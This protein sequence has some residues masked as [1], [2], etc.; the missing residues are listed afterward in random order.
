MSTCH[1]KRS[2]LHAAGGLIVCLVAGIIWQ[3][4]SQAA[5]YDYRTYGAAEARKVVQQPK[6]WITADH[7]K[8]QALQRDFA[9]PEEVTAA[10]LTCH[11]EA[12]MQV[13]KTIHWMWI[14]PADTERKMGKNGLTLNN[15]C[16]SVHSNQPRCT[17]CHAGYGW[18]DASFDFSSAERVD[19]L[20]CHDST[21]TYKKFPT[22]A[23]YPVKE[24]TPFGKETF[25]PP[26]YRVVAASVARP[27]RD[28]CGNCHF[29][30]GGG[31]GVKHGDLD[32]SMLKPSRD[33]DVHMNAEGAN[34][35]CQRCHTTEAHFIAGRSY[36][37][38]AYTERTSLI[39]NDLVKRISCESCHTDKPHKAGHKANDHT[40]RVACQTCHIP[41]YARVLPTKISWDWSQAGRMKEGKP[42]KIMGA[43]D[44]PV[45]DSMK[46]AF[47]WATNVEPEYMWYNG[48][49]DYVLAT[50]SINPT[51]VV[52]VNRV[53]G[54]RSDPNAR[55]FPI[56]VHRGKQPYDK[57]HN[58]LAIPHLFGK[59]DTAYWKNFDW[60]K[61]IA[62][63][64][65]SVG[66]PYSGEYGF[67]STE[68]H[69]PVTH[70][71]APKEKSLHCGDCHA[72]EGRLATLEG[73]YMPGRDHNGMLDKI[74]WIG[75]LA[76]LIGVLGHGLL[77]TLSRGKQE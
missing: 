54:D 30:G 59:D 50:D 34:F 12:A 6:R 63:G 53:L 33:L 62:T 42:Y 74:G 49:M 43:Y 13:H 35:T 55:I 61:A 24:P 71:V 1:R 47:V 46:G 77:R 75:T 38:P 36:K 27:A 76:A 52:K 66:I 8:H 37:K 10:C 17:S 68:Y 20:V 56:R 2:L 26:D 51:Q 72:R 40:D 4:S 70:M 29:Y 69:Y 44:R 41:A 21:G 48:R 14:D 16:I 5:Q 58:T 39:E 65:A 19:C 23:G 64:M 18:K 3:S 22:M 28:N 11:N 73:F 15:F 25:V 9:S 45:Y 31:D 32:S 57:V 67:V 7:S 60:N